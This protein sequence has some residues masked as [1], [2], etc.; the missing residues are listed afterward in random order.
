M[1]NCLNLLLSLSSLHFFTLTNACIHAKADRHRYT[2]TKMHKHTFG[3][4][5]PPIAAICEFLKGFGQVLGVHGVWLKS[6]TVSQHAFCIEHTSMTSRLETEEQAK[7]TTENCSTGKKNKKQNRQTH[8]Q[9]W[10]DT[11]LPLRFP[12]WLHF[13][14]TL[15][16]L[17]ASVSLPSALSPLDYSTSSKKEFVC[18]SSLLLLIFCLS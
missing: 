12:S 6:V 3:T 8:W 2:F 7:F 10:T 16:S 5:R 15:F 17:S 13:S 4:A 11:F 14:H 1:F 18:E 9:M